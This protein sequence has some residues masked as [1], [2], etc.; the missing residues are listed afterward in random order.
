MSVRPFMK[1]IVGGLVAGLTTLGT[2]MIDN[3][4][5]TVEWVAVAVAALGG[6]GVV[7]ATP[8]RSTTPEESE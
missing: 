6:L 3:T 1:A 8:N 7:Y 2:A 5:T 4:V